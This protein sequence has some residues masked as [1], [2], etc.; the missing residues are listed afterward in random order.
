MGKIYT[1]FC[2][3]LDQVK[4][5]LIGPRKFC[6]SSSYSH[7]RTDF[8]S[9]DELDFIVRLGEFTPNLDDCIILD[10]KYYLKNNYIYCIGDHY[11][12]LKWKIEFKNLETH[13]IHININ[14][15][16][17]ILRTMKMS[18]SLI[19]GIIIDPLIHYILTLKKSTLIHASCMT[20][21]GK[22]IILV[23]RGGAGKTTL[24]TQMVEKGSRFISDNYTILTPANELY[25][26]VEP[27]NIFSY[28]INEKIKSSLTFAHRIRLKNGELINW[29]TRGYVKIFL[30]IDPFNVFDDNAIETKARFAFLLCPNNKI[31]N[32][33]LLRITKEKMIKHIYYNQRMEFP[34]FDK[35]V[36]TYSFLFSNDKIS[37][38]LVNYEKAL[39]ENLPD[40]MGYYL[41]RY[42]PHLLQ[43]GDV[44]EMI[45]EVI[46]YE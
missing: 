29:L 9:N 14:M 30:K 45:E 4:F 10:D 43:I 40:G 21:N 20:K 24:V 35:Y 8:L 38:H 46:K 2:N 34:Y 41:I 32:A 13:P 7:Y 37:K 23:G 18:Y 16:S 26:F 42:S 36:T 25:G 28:N 15:E 27:L 1:S 33:E 11:K 44:R 31:E 12:M 6:H 39:E 5:S 17:P 19:E 22:G 3:L